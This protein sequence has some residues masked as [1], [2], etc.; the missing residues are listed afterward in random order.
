MATKSA[1]NKKPVMKNRGKNINEMMDLNL[2]APM[3]AKVRA[4]RRTMLINKLNTHRCTSP[5]ELQE[6]FE[7]LFETCF[8]NGFIP[9]VEAL[10]LCS[11]IERTTLYDMEHIKHEGYRPYANIVKSAKQFI[12]TTEAELARD[13]EINSTVY[14]FRAKNYYGMVDKQEMVVTPNTGLQ[15]P[16]NE[17]EILKNI[18]QLNE[19]NG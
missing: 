18:P 15:T 6:R 16:M 1:T 8:E 5:E 11:G 12:A 14:I 4:L 2:N 9:T 19:N 7:K 13:G 17:D 3:D 10:S